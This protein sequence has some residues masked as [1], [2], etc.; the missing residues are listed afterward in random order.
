MTKNQYKIGTI[1]N[2]VNR[3]LYADDCLNVLNDRLAIPS[4]SVD[5]IYLDPPF[6]SKSDYNLPFKGKDK[7][8]KPVAAFEDTWQWGD[9]QSAVLE[10]F[11]SGP[12]TRTIAQLIDVASRVDGPNAKF[13]LDAYLVNMAER[14]IAMRRVLKPTGSI[15]LHCDPTA[16]HYLKILM[17]VIFGR[18]NYR[19]EIVWCYTGPGSPGMRQFNRKHDTIHWYSVGDTWTFN[20]DAVRIG[21]HEK[22]KDNFK[23]GLRGSGFVD[24]Q[25]DLAEGKVPE[26]WWPQEKGN[27]F[28]IA[29]RQKGQYIG[30]PT[31]KPLALLERIIQASSNPG[32]LVLDPFCGCGTSTHAAEKLGRRWIGIDISRFATGL[33]KRRILTNFKL[34]LDPNDISAFG[35]PETPDQVRELANRDKFEFE[36]WACGH[37]GAEG[38]F[39]QPGTKGPDKGVDGVLK[40]I[41][42]EKPIKEQYAIVQVK[43]GNV[44]PDSV[45]A[46]ETT[47]RRFDAK[48]GVMICF[49]N[50]MQTVENNRSKET[51]TD[52]TQI[53]YPVIQGLSVED[54]LLRDKMPK[55]PNLMKLAGKTSA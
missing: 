20:S 10:R 7:T 6:N 50:Q 51:F 1:D 36:K 15:Y 41:P 33:V 32:D 21:H 17:D 26:T 12:A 31:Q 49:A 42:M 18:A 29:A 14:L 55:L 4:E 40:F 28:A 53:D 30:Y 23:P 2:E 11:K 43:G 27:G 48:A 52:M 25:Y 45:R 9:A 5:L 46:L 22:T 39:H 54:M 34:R 3:I 16:S 35:V 44:T 24:G 37:V 19:N 8:A 47:V 13:R 38:M